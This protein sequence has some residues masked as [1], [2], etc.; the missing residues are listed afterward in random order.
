MKYYLTK[1]WF[2]DMLY[3]LT[4][5]RGI[6]VSEKAD[7][8]DEEIYQEFYKKALDKFMNAEKSV[9]RRS[10]QTIFRGWIKPWLDQDFPKRCRRI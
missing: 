8:A 3:P 6:E 4:L 9:C 5:K 1:E 2:Y 7:R 10:M